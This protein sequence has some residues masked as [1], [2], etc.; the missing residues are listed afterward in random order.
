M[1][2]FETIMQAPLSFVRD[3]ENSVVYFGVDLGGAFL[4]LG[5]VGSGRFDKWQA[6]ADQ[7]KADKKPTGSK[8]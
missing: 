2:N 6:I 5:G 3:D 4:K 8:K 1:Q 7:A